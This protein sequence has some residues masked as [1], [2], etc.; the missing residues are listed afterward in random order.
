MTLL[1][2]F[3]ASADVRSIVVS[4]SAEKAMEPD[5]LRMSV[6]IW[7]RTPTAQRTQILAADEGKRIYAI[8]DQYKI[9]KEDIQTEGFSFSPETTWDNSRNESRVT[10]FR[11]SQTLRVTLR[12]TE[13][14]GKLI[15]ALT[16]AEKNS[17]GGSAGGPKSEVGTNISDLRWDSTKRV[18]TTDLA[19]GDAVRSARKRAD[20]IAKAAGVKVKNVYRISYGTPSYDQP[21]PRPMM[22][23]AFADGAAASGTPTNLSGGEV[24]VSASVTAEFEIH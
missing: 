6:E 20:E 11:S 8:L 4:T 9:R 13:V 18:E 2:P 10:G 15:D 23:A 21:S 19:M 1:F 24:K 14:G 12:K 3:L 17:A 7:S 16:V 22:K 5:L